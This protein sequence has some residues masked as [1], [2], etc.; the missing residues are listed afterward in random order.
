MKLISSSFKELSLFNISKSQDTTS[1]INLSSSD[2]YYYDEKYFRLLT[3]NYA[4]IV[5][6]F[7]KHP[8]L[9]S[10]YPE[11]ITALI[12]KCKND[13]IKEFIKAKCQGSRMDL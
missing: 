11:E 3:N 2:S 4:E 7:E 6:L 12:V 10:E 5:A 1:Q 9:V 13:Q 8:T